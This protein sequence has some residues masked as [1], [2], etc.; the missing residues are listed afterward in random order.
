MPAELGRLLVVDDEPDFARFVTT[1]A[2]EVGFAVRAVELSSDFEFQLA[3]WHPTVVFLDVFMPERDGL[4]LLGTLERRGY[5]GHI[6]MMS[7]VESLYLNMAA[8]SAKMR[9]LRLSAV[10]SKP[11]RKQELQELLQ[12]LAG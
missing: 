12:K 2:S 4:E 11:C 9:G 3:D 10:L 7:G 1:V 5:D 6:V 8:A